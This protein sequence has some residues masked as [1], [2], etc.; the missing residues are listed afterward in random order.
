MERGPKFDL[1]CLLVSA[2]DES[3][4]LHDSTAGRLGQLYGFLVT[5]PAVDATATAVHPQQVPEPKI[6]YIYTEN[7]GK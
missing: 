3:E 6:L 7:A 4:V 5:H 1:L 2:L